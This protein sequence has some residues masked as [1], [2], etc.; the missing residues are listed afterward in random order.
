MTE[1]Q[2]E[3]AIKRAKPG[4]TQ[5]IEIMKLFS[6]TNV[7][8]DQI[9][10]R[11][12]NAFYRIRQRPVEWYKTYYEYMEHLKSH[13]V[14]FTVVLRYLKKE[15]KRYEPSFS[16][17][18]VATLDPSKP[19][20]D[21]YVLNNIHLPAP[22][23]NSPSKFDEAEAIYQKIE[24]WFLSF[25]RSVEGAMIIRKFDELISSHIDISNTKKIDFW[26][27]QTRPHD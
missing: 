9:F 19:V 6:Q 27:W 17:K 20:W 8:R 4:V 11:K 12:Y 22:S 7:A 1:N 26:L 2:V 10:Q 21:K 16:S 5:Y 3:E 18:L 13:A 25:E 23:Y 14:T 15:L 24:D